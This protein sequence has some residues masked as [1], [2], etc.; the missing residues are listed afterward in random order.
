MTKTI[1]VADSS[2]TMRQV[3]TIALKGE[4]YDVIEA[5][6]GRDALS[7][8]N[9]VPVHLMISELAMPNM[10]GI[11]F[12][13]AARQLPAYKFTPFIMLGSEVDDAMKRDGQTAGAKAWLD[14][15]FQPAQMLDAVSRLIRPK[16][17]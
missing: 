2:V 12:L 7:K 10:G 13:K 8:L 16:Y 17:A 5:V 14:K 1:L 9:G 11:E 6:D 15:P 4:G 3:M